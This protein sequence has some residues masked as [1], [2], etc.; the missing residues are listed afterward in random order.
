M[1]LS[2]TFS[3]V[4]LIVAVVAMI[5]F[6]V[7]WSRRSKPTETRPEDESSRLERDRDARKSP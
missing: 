7:V 1:E 6:Y 5:T 4:L 2:F 3:Y